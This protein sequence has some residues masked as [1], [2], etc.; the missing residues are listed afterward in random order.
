MRRLGVVLLLAL[1]LSGLPA[2]A[3]DDD[4]SS[5][6]SH[7]NGLIDG[8]YVSQNATARQIALAVIRNME[9]REGMNSHE[10]QRR[11]NLVIE[12][13]GSYWSAYQTV[14]GYPRR[15]GG[16]LILMAGGGGLEMNIS[17]CDGAVSQVHW[18]R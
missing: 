10:R 11:Y 18:S 5:V 8:P 16:A 1:T 6:C 12:D 7:T 15:Q 2:S 14:R 9:L 17:K 4:A 3:Q 13:H